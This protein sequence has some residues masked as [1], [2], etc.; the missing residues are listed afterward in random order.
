MRSNVKTIKLTT[1][2]SLI[3]A[4]ITYIISIKGILGMGELKWLPDVFLLAV[5][6]GAFASMLV[7]LICEIGKYYDNRVSTET[8]LFAHLCYLYGHLQIILKNIN[9]MMNHNDR[10]HKDAL[11]QL[12]HNAEAEMNTVYYTEYVPYRNNNAIFTEKMKYNRDVFPIIQ[13]YLQN[14]RVFEVAVLTDAITKTKN[15][16]GKFSGPDNNASLVLMKLS[17]QI[18]EPLLLL[19]QL[20]TK[21]DHLCHD[22]YNWQQMRDDLLKDIPDN[23]NDWLEQFLRKN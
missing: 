16:M 19:D 15:E 10:I 22:R 5:F 11:S 1:W 2:L 7:V 4:G 3:F 20:L 6:G 12:I 8:L 23:R 13:C 14:C 9:F 21:I 17:E 18:Q